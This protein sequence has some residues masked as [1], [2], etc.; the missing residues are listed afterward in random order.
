MKLP[1]LAP[2]LLSGCAVLS[3]PPGSQDPTTWVRVADP[4]PMVW[5]QIPGAEV[6][7]RCGF[8]FESVRMGCAFRLKDGPQGAYCLVLAPISE[9]EAMTT[10]LHTPTGAVRSLDGQAETLWSHEKKHCEGFNH[11]RTK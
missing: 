5:Q 10:W 11:E 9:R 3:S 1:L 6:A 7:A 2:L 4:M 8:K